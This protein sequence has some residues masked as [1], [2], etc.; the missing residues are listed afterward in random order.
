MKNTPT[1]DAR[2]R[3]QRSSGVRA[4]TGSPAV[5]S[6]SAERRGPSRGGGG[7][8]GTCAVAKAPATS[9]ADW[10]SSMGALPIARAAPALSAPSAWAPNCTAVIPVTARIMSAPATC[11]SSVSRAGMTKACTVPMARPNSTRPGS[12]SR[13]P[14]SAAASVSTGSAASRWRPHQQAARVGALRRRAAEQEQQQGGQHRGGLGEADPARARLQLADDEPGEQHLLH[15]P[16]AEPG[17]DAR[18]EPAVRA[19]RRPAPAVRRRRCERRGGLVH[20]S[21]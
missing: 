16:R 20:G 14:A 3:G 6:R 4:T 18:G 1:Q 8:A 12:E 2:T 19:G 9:T 17:A 10:T 21:R 15:A 5:S 7:A 13:P 11:E